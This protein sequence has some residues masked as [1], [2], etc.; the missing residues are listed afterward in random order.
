MIHSFFLYLAIAGI[1]IAF[2]GLGYF[3][4]QENNLTQKAEAIIEKANLVNYGKIN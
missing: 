3:Y 1:G 2:L 4:W